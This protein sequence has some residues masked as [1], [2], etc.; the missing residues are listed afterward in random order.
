[1]L[2]LSLLPCAGVALPCKLRSSFLPALPSR[3]CFG[4]AVSQIA[5][6]AP[7]PAPIVSPRLY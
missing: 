7:A 3:P 5:E 6:A 2:C 4:A 1:M